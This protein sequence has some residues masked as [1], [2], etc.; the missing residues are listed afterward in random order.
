M[1]TNSTWY[2]NHH[3]PPH[4][5][6]CV[7]PDVPHGEPNRPAQSVRV[8]LTQMSTLVSTSCRDSPRSHICR[9][10]GGAR[11]GAF[12]SYHTGVG[13]VPPASTHKSHTACAQQSAHS[14]QLA[15]AR[16][17]HLWRAISWGR[18]LPDDLFLCRAL[19]C[20]GVHLGAAGR[21]AKVAQ[22]PGPVCDHQHI[23]RLEVPDGVECSGSGGGKE[24]GE[25]GAA[26]V[27]GCWVQGV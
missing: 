15:A 22:H 6:T 12:C 27:A 3:A 19:C 26:G 10:K 17:S 5:S 1:S 21:A 16:P 24:Q 7:H 23:L 9:K 2:A 11:V 14:S 4:K 8:P 13:A 20:V 18:V 25:R